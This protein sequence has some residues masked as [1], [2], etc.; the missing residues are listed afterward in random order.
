MR[1]ELPPRPSLEHLKKQAKDLLDAHQRKDPE[2]LARI[3]DALPS[4]ARMSDDDVAR[5]PFALHDAQSAIARE[6]GLPSWNALRDAVA[7]RTAE[8]LPDDLLRALMPLHFPHAVGDALR[9]AWSRRAA[10]QGTRKTAAPA[11]PGALPL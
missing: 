1:R 10:A 3:R 11:L 4:F 5:A 2:A 6:H 8:P 9:D 7:E